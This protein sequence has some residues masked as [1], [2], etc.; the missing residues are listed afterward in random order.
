MFPFAVTDL[1]AYFAGAWR[2]SRRIEDHGAGNTG[3]FEGRAEFVPD[4]PELRYHEAGTMSLGAFSGG[5]YRDYV[6]AFPT[7]TRAEVRFPDGRAFHAVDLAAG[8]AD[9]R[10]LCGDDTYEGRYDLDG[11]AVWTLRWRI[12]GP[13]KDLTLTGIYQRPQEP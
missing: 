5:A 2:L 11:P 4:G 6:Y 8:A 13:H 1:K 3:T 9:A 12:V 10:H 7:P